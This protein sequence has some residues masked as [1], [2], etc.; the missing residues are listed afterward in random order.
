MGRG[1]AA[2]HGIEGGG[3]ELPEPSSIRHRVR[4]EIVLSPVQWALCEEAR[5]REMAGVP[6]EDWIRYRLARLLK[7]TA[8]EENG[9]PI[10]KELL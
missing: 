1:R 6:L 8:Q 10:P 4:V 7:E 5:D 2:V 3:Q 9:G